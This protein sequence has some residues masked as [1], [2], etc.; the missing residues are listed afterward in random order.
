MSK[1]PAKKKNEAESEEERSE[2]N[3]VFI[4]RKP[5]M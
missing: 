3:M 1:K 4:G 2:E 5:T